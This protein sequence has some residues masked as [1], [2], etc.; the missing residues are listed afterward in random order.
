[1]AALQILTSIL[2]LLLGVFQLAATFA[3]LEVWVG[4]HWIIAGPLAFFL[5]YIPLVGTIVGMFGAVEAWGW[6]WGQAGALFFGPFI[7]IF[8]LLLISG[9]IEALSG[10]R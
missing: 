10:R 7:V 8:I 5:A 1:M 9:G 2:Y 6:S 3:G 4:L